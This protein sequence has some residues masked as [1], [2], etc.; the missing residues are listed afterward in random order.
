[1]IA[2]YKVHTKDDK[3]KI[4]SADCK[5]GGEAFQIEARMKTN[6]GLLNARLVEYDMDEIFYACSDNVETV[7][8]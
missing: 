3:F 2:I 6:P 8:F 4:V 5:S 1:M 7:D